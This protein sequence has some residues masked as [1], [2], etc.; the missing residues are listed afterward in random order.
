MVVNFKHYF[1]SHLKQLLFSLYLG[2]V[3]CIYICGIFS[4]GSS[5]TLTYLLFFFIAI[6]TYITSYF[7]TAIIMK[8]VSKV[9][10]KQQPTLTRKKAFL[11]LLISFLSTI[12]IAGV[13]FFAYKPGA[14]SEDS[15]GQY[16]QAISGS[17]NDWHPALHTFIAFTIPLSIFHS[18]NAIIIC[19][20]IIFAIAIAYAT[21]TVYKIA[22]KR[23]SIFTFLIVMANP[24]ALDGLMFPWKDISFAIAALLLVTMSLKIYYSHGNWGNKITNLII[25]AII[26]SFATI[27]R[28]NGILFTAPLLLALLFF[29]KRKQWIKI[30]VFSLIAIFIIKVPFYSLLGVVTPNRGA[31][32]TLGLPLTML[33]NVAK[34]EPDNLS[35]TTKDFLYSIAPAEVWEQQYSTGDFNTIKWSG[36]NRE[37]VS[38]LGTIKVLSLTA[39]NLITSPKA[40]LS[41]FFGATQVVYGIEG[42]FPAYNLTPGL[43]PNTQG[44]EYS[45]SPALRKAVST[46]RA[47]IDNSILH[48]IGC[49][50]ITIIIMLSFIFGKIDYRNSEWK[51]ALLCSPVFFYDFG[52]MLLLTGPETRF[53]YLN[54]ILFPIIII[55]ALCTPM[56]KIKKIKHINNQ[57]KD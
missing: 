36:I 2:T 26:T 7:I 1:R 28:H 22:G 18:P 32:E 9:S 19:Q 24:Y 49:I 39:Q 52:T 38:E 41:G 57:R 17:Y 16:E 55:T 11:V 6:L 29:L 3:W 20:I 14:F 13:W 53:F 31:D 37:P 4:G 30:V 44:I 25:F 15:F 35:T 27:F 21:T 54:Y 46:Y 23:W 5:N 8:L 33:A 45:G 48:Y 47:I 40:S 10:L 42:T 43:E 50:G 56:P 34:T 12:I 51:K